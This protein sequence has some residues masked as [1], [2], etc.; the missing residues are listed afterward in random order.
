MVLTSRAQGPCAADQ[1]TGHVVDC[2]RRLAQD[3][4][5]SEGPDRHQRLRAVFDEA[6]LREASALEAYLDDACASDPGLRRDVLRLIAA[7]QESESF[8][9]HPPDLRRRPARTGGDFPGTGRFRVGRRLGAGGMGIVYEAHDGVRDEVVAL[10]T[11]LRTGAADLYRLKREFRSLA[12]VTHPN[13]VCLYELFVEGDRCFFTMELVDGVSFVEYARGSDGIDRFDR[14][15]VPALRQLIEGVSALHG[16]GKLHRDIKPANVLV[17]PDGRVVI[18]DFGL[19]AELLPRHAGE[20]SYVSGGTPAYMSPEEAAGAIPSE[21]GDWY[22][23]GVTLYE[24]LT[25]TIPF[26]GPV[27]DVLLRKSIFDPPAPADLVPDVPGDLSA[28]C[29]GLLRRNPEQRLSGIEVLRRLAR[30]SVA[31]VLDTTPA[32]TREISFVGRGRQLRTLNDA[33]VTVS[34]GAAAAVSVYGPSGIGKSALVRRFLGQVSVPDMVV[35][36][37][38]CYEN[39]SVPYKALDGVIDDL[40]R[41]L[42]AIPRADVK[43][44]VPPDVTALTRVFPVLLQVDAFAH[45]HRHHDLDITDLF[46]V[47]R[48][49]FDA[50]RELLDRLVRRQPLVMCIDD[51]QWADADSA[52]L[53]QDLLRA[54]SSPPMLTLLCFRSEEMA[55]KPFLQALVELAG[56]G[57]WSAISL[58]P[59]TEEEADTL[60]GALLPAGSG[61]SDEDRRSMT[62]EARGSPFVL[63]QLARYAGADR[64]DRRR[65]PTLSEMFETRLAALPGNAR[66]FVETLAIC[67][68]PVAPDLICRACGI[69]RE[70]HSLVARLRSSRFIR[71]SG[72][73]ERIETYHDRIREVLAARMVPD[74]VRQT[75]RVMVEALVE[76]QSDDCEALFE[77]YRGAGDPA[78]ASIQAG[79]AAQKAAGALAFDRAASFY[80]HALALTSTSTPPTAWTEGLA[81]ALANAGRPAEAAEAYLHAADGTPHPHRIELQRRSAEQFLIGGH[82]DRGLDLIRTS[83]AGLGVSVP[84]SPFAA[85][86]RLVWHRAQLRWRGLHFVSRPVADIGTDALLRIDTCWAATMGLLA[87]DM[88]G[89]SNFSARHLLMALDAGEP[90]RIAR[91]MAMEFA[92]TGLFQTGRAWRESLARQSKALAKTV[93]QPQA[94]AFPILADAIDATLRG[95]WKKASTLAEQALVIF[96]DECVGVTWEVNVAQNL[97]IWSLMY[98]GEFRELSQRVP[99]L[100]AHAR[101]S[102]NLYIATE[103][104]TRSNFV[105]LAADDPDEG[106]RETVE[107]IGRWSH[108]GFHRQH[109]SAR[110]ARVQTA[111]YRGDADAAWRLF[112]EQEAMLR[113]SLLTRVQVIRVEALYL[114][115]RVALAMAARHGDFRRF[116]PIARAGARRITRERRPW[117]HPLGLLIRAGIASV[118]GSHSAAV[119]Y[120]HDAAGRF[121][122]ADMNLYAAVTR[123]RIGELQDDAAGRDMYRQA[124]EWMSVQG[125]KNPAAMTRMLAPGFPEIA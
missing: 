29:M 105:W 7:Y 50:L 69:T 120:L 73:S 70:R 86:L 93:G 64:G 124:V 56:R 114:Q 61:I 83:L 8:L 71:S 119:S 58:E 60:I 44:L 34:N 104:C 99:V 110:L 97:V 76:T 25:G 22:G 23:I 82:I 48:R 41:Y 95:E 35:L 53:L 18:L 66:R 115:S 3:S 12:D 101:S 49:A 111:L 92:A 87:V 5:V 11:L 17:T 106:E 123:R 112:V 57:M 79:L 72:S 94:I 65:A 36:S 6:L 10:K 19:M 20:T 46:G 84:E 1:Y 43:S 67:G 28:L 9:E 118:E 13:L 33:L 39:E 89:A 15:I 91:G 51:L 75:H 98:Q 63:E 100:L 2:G 117:S 80:R 45:V 125:V 37:G 30:D 103:L 78:N 85:L 4:P 59:M 47:R 77:H 54:P 96:R 24:A 81:N 42:A 107:S 113:R 109:Y 62:R 121:A 116:L 38:R 16:R 88:I 52:V 27:A 74:A 90:H 55:A 68:R 21:A 122:R 26:S 102:G 108:K 40:S 14:R 31:P 32:P